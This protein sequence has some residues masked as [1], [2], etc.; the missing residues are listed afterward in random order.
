MS[1][2]LKV[3]VEYVGEHPGAAEIA[4][5]KGQDSKGRLHSATLSAELHHANRDAG[6]L[7]A[8]PR[9][10]SDAGSPI[11]TGCHR[12]GGMHNSSPAGHIVNLCNSTPAVA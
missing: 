1:T 7:Q 10:D 11:E 6:H 5:W 8:S 4:F 12:S 3:A 9:Q 2:R